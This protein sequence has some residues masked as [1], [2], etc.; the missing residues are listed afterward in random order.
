M[1]IND[2]LS[3]NETL[4]HG[5]VSRIIQIHPSLNCNLKCKHCYSSSA[6]GLKNGLDVGLLINI[7]E[8]ASAIGYN[9]ISMSGG[10]PFLYKSIEELTRQS[11]SIG[12]F[13]SVT[14]NGML[15]ETSNTKNTLKYLDLVAISI[16]GKEE[17]HDT[18]RSH[19]GAFKKMLQGVEILK[20]EIK[21][22]GFIHTLLPDSWKLLPWLTEFAMDHKAG[23]LHL[24]PLEM[25]GR[26]N[27]NF[28]GI[29]FTSNDLHKIYIACHYLKTYYGNDLFIQ[30]DLLHK[31]NI[32]DNPNFLFHQTFKPEFTCESFSSIFKEL[33]IDDKGD[34]FPIAYGCSPFF[35]IGNIASI[36]KLSEMIEFFMEKKMDSMIRLFNDTYF[37]IVNHKDFEIFNWSERIIANSR[38]FDN[39]IDNTKMNKKEEGYSIYV[40][41]GLNVLG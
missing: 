8:Q 1:D 32:I 37:E 30:L 14:S 23:L 9:V 27:Q 18:M 28:N 24:H 25:S 22:Y 26:A 21:N 16:D 5:R 29:Q 7:L 20:G 35:K 40:D 13:N 11:K 6:P 39:E 15:F 31:D 19:K 2:D 41:E 3:S 33:I 36:R 34:I 17:S 10:E 38:F 12:Y 4:L